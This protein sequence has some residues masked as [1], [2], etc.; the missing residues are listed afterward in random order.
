MNSKNQSSGF[1]SAPLMLIV[2][3]LIFAGGW[4]VY[5]GGKDTQHTLLPTFPFSTVTTP[6]VST[7]TTSIT[8]SSSNVTV[9]KSVVSG[10][11]SVSKQ[12][13]QKRKVEREDDGE[14]GDDDR[15]TVQT[16]TQTQ[17]KTN[18]TNTTNTT[19][20]GTSYTLTQV[21]SH[22][23]ASNCWTTINGFVYNITSYI[24]QHPGGTGAIIALC[25]IDSSADFNLQHG[26]QA[27]PASELA[28]FKIGTLA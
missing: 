28:S 21:A 4:Y 27:R 25:G 9:K 3:T 20:T 19:S 12:T 7:A 26:G 10:N 22:N 24:S 14:N 6:P 11:T 15:R 16:Q 2:A 8:A 23:N 1:I 18:T 13:I 5:N 17:T